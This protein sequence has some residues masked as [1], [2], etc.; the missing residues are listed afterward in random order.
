MGSDVTL[1]FPEA[2]VVLIVRP[3]D[4]TAISTCSTRPNHGTARMARS[5]QAR[6]RWSMKE[7]GGFLPFVGGQGPAYSGYGGIPS[8][9]C[10]KTFRL[11]TNLALQEG[12]CGETP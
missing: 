12:T 9:G 5:D 8:A 11:P 6:S 2:L 3:L 1:S 7:R 4:K 10:P